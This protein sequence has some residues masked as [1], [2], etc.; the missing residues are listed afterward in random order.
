MRDHYPL[1]LLP[2]NPLTLTLLPIN[3]G[4]NVSD[5]W[6]VGHHQGRSRRIDHTLQS[7]QTWTTRTRQRHRYLLTPH[8]LLPP[9][10]YPLTVFLSPSPSIPYPLQSDQIWA[11]RTGKGHRYL[12]S[13]PIPRTPNTYPP[14]P[15]SL[16]HTPLTLIL[17]LIPPTVKSDLSIWNREGAQALIN[18]LTLISYLLPLTRIP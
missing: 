4:D 10:T 9:N 11:T 6:G 8:P 2:P 14:N 3:V 5:R 12:T 17:Y 18:T 1:I 16:N 7:D 15:Y 13:Y